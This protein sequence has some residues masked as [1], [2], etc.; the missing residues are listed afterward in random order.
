MG[1]QG[2]SKVIDP[3]DR[4]ELVMDGRIT[5][6]LNS[7]HEICGVHKI[8]GTPVSTEHLIECAQIA[9]T[10]VDSISKLLHDELKQADETYQQHRLAQLRGTEYMP[11]AKSSL[12]AFETSQKAEDVE[13]DAA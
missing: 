8:G 11:E 6:S 4:E 7:H 10:Q 2:E 5:F 1:S 13:F 12:F 3:S 9:A